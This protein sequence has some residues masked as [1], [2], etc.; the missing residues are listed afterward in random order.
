MKIKIW[1]QTKQY[2]YGKNTIVHAFTFLE[3]R[4][5]KLYLKESFLK[6]LSTRK[7]LPV[8][9]NFDQVCFY[10][11]SCLKKHQTTFRVLKMCEKI[12]KTHFFELYLASENFGEVTPLKKYPENCRPLISFVASTTLKLW[13]KLRLSSKTNGTTQLYKKNREK[14]R[15]M[16]NFG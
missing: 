13:W 7:F 8:R 5:W 14:F 16:F 10:S 1:E 4:N 9:H 15:L 3:K 2:Y 12:R 11:P 6:F